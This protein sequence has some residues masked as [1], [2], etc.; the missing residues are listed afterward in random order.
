MAER[1]V[2]SSLRQLIIAYDKAARREL[3]AAA[4]E[5]G[6]RV[7]NKHRDVVKSWSQK[8]D[9]RLDIDVAPARIEILVT[10]RGRNK[11]RFRYVNEGTRAHI[12]RP[13]KTKALHFRT[14]HNPKTRPIAQY[15]VGDG[16]STGG[17]VTAKQVK[18]PGTKPR[19][20][21]EKFMRDELP[22]FKRE[23]EN[24]LRRA[25]RRL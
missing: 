7:L 11:K 22:D 9:F 15:N 13:R 1:G 17:F 10:P 19:K 2:R 14:G 25:A 23:C 21:T 4:E 5:T 8:P 6:R 24:A 18:H 20:F 12:I 16:G 3:R